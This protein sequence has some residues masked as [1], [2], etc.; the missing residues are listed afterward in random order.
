M[1]EGVLPAAQAGELAVVDPVDLR[2]YL[3]DEPLEQGISGGIHDHSVQDVVGG[4]RRADIVGLER[5][6]EIVVGSAHDRDHVGR[7]IGHSRLHRQLVQHLQDGQRRF[8]V[9]AMQR[10]DPGECGGFGLYQPGVDQP[11]QGLAHRS[12]AQAQLVGQIAVAN[13]R[14]GGELAGD[15]RVADP[16]E[17]DIAHAS[18]LNPVA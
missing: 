15:D 14:S 5:P 4:Q 10:S 13:L 7:E 17:R 1:L 3:L 18:S 6:R 9:R 12:P 8:D 16:I 2:V 11:G